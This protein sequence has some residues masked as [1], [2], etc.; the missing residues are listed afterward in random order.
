VKLYAQFNPRTGKLSVPQG[1]IPA[2]RF[3]RWLTGSAVGAYPPEVTVPAFTH[4]DAFFGI[5]WVHTKYKKTKKGNKYYPFARVRYDHKGAVPAAMDYK[6]NWYWID[7]S[8]GNF[9]FDRNALASK[10]AHTAAEADS[11]NYKGTFNSEWKSYNSRQTCTLQSGKKALKRKA[12]K[13][14]PP[15]K[16]QCRV[17][18]NLQKKKRAMHKNT[19]KSS[20]KKL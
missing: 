4:D 1:E 13:Y 3:R 8:N 17:Y 18:R 12:I 6:V 19:K 11:G 10:F 7:M 9:H 20:K 14:K 15:T 2:N 5:R 16:S